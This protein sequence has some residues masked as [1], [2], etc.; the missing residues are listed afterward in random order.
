LQKLETAPIVAGGH[1]FSN[2]RLSRAREV[3]RSG[4]NERGRRGDSIP[5]L[6]YQGDASWRS[7]FAGEEAPAGLFMAA[8]LQGIKATSWTTS[9]AFCLPGP[10]LRL[11]WLP[12]RLHQVP[13]G[14]FDYIANCLIMSTTPSTTFLTPSITFTTTSTIS[15]TA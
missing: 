11:L 2:S 10:Q 1:N 12:H 6:T 4:A 8:V 13:Y 14:F 7:N 5:Y 3:G 9:S 15:S